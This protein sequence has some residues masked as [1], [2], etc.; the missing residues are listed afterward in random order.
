MTFTIF[1]SGSTGNAALVSSGDV[2]ILLDA[3]ISARRLSQRLSLL[4]LT[5]SDLSAALIT[6]PHSDHIAGLDT[7]TR[8]TEFPIYAT[9]TVARQLCYRMAIDEKVH[10]IQ[11]NE[12]FSIQD[13][14]VLPI[15]TSHDTPG[16][17]GY[18]LTSPE[19][20]AACLVTDLGMVTDDVRQG[21]SGV[22]LAVIECNHDPDCL[23]N[24]PYPYPLKQRIAGP[25]GHLSN[26]DGAA[27]AALAAQTAHTVVL[28]HL[29]Q[30]NNSP[31]LALAAAQEALTSFPDV[32]VAVA[33]PLC[34]GLT[35]E[36]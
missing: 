1:A 33:P 24:G 27:L 3:G 29:S 4:G 15:P 31:A 36:V 10:T 8:H 18:R 28:A 25:Q 11:P 5:A 34:D 14:T 19:G 22:D 7:L 9:P 35:W 20:R 23:V 12:G 26:A 13:I 30:H 17:V 32:K 21:V 6:H 2:H 16:S